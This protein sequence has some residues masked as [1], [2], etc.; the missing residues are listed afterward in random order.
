[1]LVEVIILFTLNVGAK[2]LITKKYILV[3]LLFGENCLTLENYKCVRKIGLL[4]KNNF[5]EKNLKKKIT[6]GKNCLPSPKSLLS[7]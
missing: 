3:S 1:M 2:C 4:P 6:V 7:E 5:K